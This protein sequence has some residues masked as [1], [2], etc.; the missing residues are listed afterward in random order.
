MMANP[1]TDDFTVRMFDAINGLMLDMLAA[2]ARTARIAVVK[3][4]VRP[5][6]R[7]EVFKRIARRIQP[8]MKAVQRC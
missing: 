6:R 7:P 2:M 1:K 3:L 4:K 8:T 5:R